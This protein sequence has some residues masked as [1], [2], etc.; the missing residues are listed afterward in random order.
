MKR[1]R[2]S[3]LRAIARAAK[4]GKIRKVRPGSAVKSGWDSVAPQQHTLADEIDNTDW[5]GAK[6]NSNQRRTRFRVSAD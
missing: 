4:L 2:A 5:I 6:A 3:E 1:S